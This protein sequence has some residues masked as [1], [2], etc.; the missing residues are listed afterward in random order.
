[1]AGNKAAIKAR[2]KS[3][4]TTKKIT[5][6]M[7]LISTVKLQKN[8]NQMEKTIAYNDTLEDVLVQILSGENEI[9]S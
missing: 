8:R 1:M 7:E 3:I 9:N 4:N 5:G 2:I 6:A